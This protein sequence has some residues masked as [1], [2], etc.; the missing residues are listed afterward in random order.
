MHLRALVPGALL[1]TALAAAQDAPPAACQDQAACTKTKAVPVAVKVDE[2][3]CCEKAA[4]V[5]ISATQDCQA[6]AAWGHA[7]HVVITLPREQDRY[8]MQPGWTCPLSGLQLGT[9]SG[10]TIAPGQ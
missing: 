8:K 10:L 9:R 3:A 2:K 4:P 7:W 6:K 5:A 1:L